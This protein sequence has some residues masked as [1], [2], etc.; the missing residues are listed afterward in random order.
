[1]QATYWLRRSVAASP[2]TAEPP[3]ATTPIQKSRAVAAA[4]V[5][6]PLACAVN[7]RAEPTAK[8]LPSLSLAVAVTYPDAANDVLVSRVER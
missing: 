1:M 5:T 6:P 4:L 2:D 7:A 8:R 3:P